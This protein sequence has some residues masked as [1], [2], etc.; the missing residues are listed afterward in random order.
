MKQC[1]LMHE[2]LFKGDNMSKGG[3]RLRLVLIRDLKLVGNG[4]I[5]SP[6]LSHHQLG[7]TASFA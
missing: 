7:S 3:F 6:P 1:L 2:M 5:F 4:S